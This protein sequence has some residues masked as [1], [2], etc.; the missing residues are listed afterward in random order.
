[1]G[2]DNFVFLFERFWESPDVAQ[3]DELLHDDVKLV[4]P[5]MPATVGL[6]QARE[7]F[8]RIFALLP[9]IRARIHRWGAMGDSVL[10]E[11]TIEASVGSDQI[12]WSGVDRFT[13]RDDKAIER[14]SYFDP[15]PL[16]RF[17][18]RHPSLWLRSWSALRAALRSPTAHSRVSTPRSPA[19]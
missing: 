7:A 1:M 18:L 12:R 3:L 14:V 15:T 10:I 5:M 17:L 4:A 11:F 16:A 19:N 6:E 13:L 9:G 8:A 2:M